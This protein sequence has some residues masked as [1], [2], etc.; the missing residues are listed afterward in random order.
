MTAVAID[1]TVPVTPGKAMLALLPFS[2]VGNPDWGDYFNAWVTSLIDLALGGSYAPNVSGNTD[3]AVSATN[4]AYAFHNLSG[5]L[6]GNINY[7][8]PNNGGFYFIYNG[9]TGSYSL[10]V[11]AAGGT[12]TQIPRGVMAIVFVS[13][14]SVNA[15]VATQIQRNPVNVNFSQSPYSVK[16]TDGLVRVDTSGGAVVINLLPVSVAP[17]VPLTILALN[18]NSTIT[19]EGDAD[20]GIGGG[21][22]YVLPQI[23]GQTAT[24]QPNGTSWDV[25]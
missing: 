17:Q 24:V 9:T 16:A 22:S 25:I 8:L 4:A 6:T 5:A 1:P 12:A 13:S 20:I 11:K 10:S 3:F 2:Y 15:L 19:L 14:G 7:V 18:N 21:T 23:A